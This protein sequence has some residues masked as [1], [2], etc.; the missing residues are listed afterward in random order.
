MTFRNGLDSLLRPEDS[1]LLLIDH[2]PYQLAN[3][4][5]HPELIA[6]LTR[7]D[8]EFIPVGASE[9]FANPVERQVGQAKKILSPLK[10]ESTKS[11]YQQPNTCILY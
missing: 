9:Q 10:E 8:V 1:V 4:T 7:N 3:L 2:Q 6:E 5:S 11:I